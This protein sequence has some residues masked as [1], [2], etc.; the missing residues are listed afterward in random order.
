M[1]PPVEAS[2]KAAIRLT[3]LP[4]FLSSPPGIHADRRVGRDIQYLLFCHPTFVLEGLVAGFL[5][6]PMSHCFHFKL[7]VSRATLWV[8][9]LLDI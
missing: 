4:L 7:P 2:A 3:I 9:G 5:L 1:L 8:S 6:A